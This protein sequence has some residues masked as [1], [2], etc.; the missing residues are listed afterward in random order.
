MIEGTLDDE[1]IEDMLDTY[2]LF[3]DI[4]IEDEGSIVH[5]DFNGSKH[6]QNDIKEDEIALFT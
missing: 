6:R 4:G 1:S 5:H 2:F 3:V